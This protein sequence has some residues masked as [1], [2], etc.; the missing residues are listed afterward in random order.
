MSVFGG[1]LMPIFQ[2]C[3]LDENEQ[4]VRTEVLGSRDEVDARREAMT[5]MMRVGRFAGYELW[6]EGRK[7]AEHRPVKEN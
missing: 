4:T 3:F 6:A 7:I 2:C 1:T 5:L